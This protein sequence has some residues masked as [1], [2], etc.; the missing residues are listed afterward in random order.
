MRNEQ[1]FYDNPETMR[2]EWWINGE[3]Y[4]F[5]AAEMLIVLNVKGMR[6]WDSGHVQGDLN[7]MRKDDKAVCDE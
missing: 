7:A 3:M 1:C 6:H 2:R 4:G 5:I